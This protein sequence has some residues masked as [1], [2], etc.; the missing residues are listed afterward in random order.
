MLRRFII[1]SLILFLLVS[2]CEDKKEKEFGSVILQFD[3]QKEVEVLYEED[4][5]DSQE[6][7]E[8]ITTKF[9]DQILTKEEKDP[10]LIPDKLDIDIIEQDESNIDQKKVIKTD[11]SFA[12]ITIGT[13]TPVTLDLSSQTSYSRTDIIEG[14]VVIKVELLNS[15]SLILY[16]ESKSVSII[17]NERASAI[18]NSW[19]VMNQSIVISSGEPNEQYTVGNTVNIA[20]GNTHA[21]RPVDIFL[22]QGPGS[23]SQN[24]IKQLE[25]DIIGNSFSWNTE[26]EPPRS[27]LGLLVSSTIQP[28]VSS[29]V[30]CFNIIAPNIA[31]VV[32]NIN[33]STDEDVVETITLLGTDANNDDLTYSIISTPSNGTLSSISGN[34]VSYTPNQD[35]N[36]A[37]TFIYKANDGATD[38]NTATVTITVNA[39]NDPPT[40]SDINIFMEPGQTSTT[41]TLS[42]SDIEG[43]ALTYSLWGTTGGTLSG[44]G[45]S[46]NNEVI[47]SPFN[48]FLGTASFSYKANDSTSDSNIATVF[49]DVKGFRMIT[50]NGGETFIEGE[51]RTIQW[52][53]GYSG[54]GDTYLW[55]EDIDTQQASALASGLN[56]Q[57]AF[58][59]TIPSFSSDG[60]W[61]DQGRYNFSIIAATS[62]GGTHLASDITDN[63]FIIAPTGDVVITDPLGGQTYQ[64]GSIITIEWVGGFTNNG[65]DLLREDGFGSTVKELDISK[66]VGN[67]NSYSWSVP[68]NLTADNDYAIRIY[69]ATGSG[70]SDTSENFSITNL[71]IISPIGSEVWYKGNTYNIQ[72]TGDI[73]TQGEARVYLDDTEI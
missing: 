57:N 60:S 41:V 31:P 72:W 43:N 44:L 46:Q 50:P 52:E 12:R 68:S 53:G 51:T 40:V 26:S 63:Y 16:Q 37:D 29:S 49:I 59:W 3:Y 39:I 27:N 47:F 33:E 54:A 6:S 35:W 34:T 38:S 19:Q 66:D 1:P 64:Q 73:S 14:N 5:K 10:F 70:A 32:S 17:K 22:Y 25:D 15:D 7:D 9:I 56:G 28:N 13:F 65:I 30:C 42:G 11:I 24:L 61:P 55:I 23:A 18:F 20:W 71:D 67:A 21:D 62:I 8:D 69:D 36:G 48:T 4:E 58:D 45:G 2:S